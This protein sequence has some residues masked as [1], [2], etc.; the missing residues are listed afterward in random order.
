[1]KLS[2]RIE[3]LEHKF[4][5]NEVTLRMAPGARSHKAVD[6]DDRGDPERVDRSRHASSQ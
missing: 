5:D 2:K 4:S 1:V 6:S 3:L